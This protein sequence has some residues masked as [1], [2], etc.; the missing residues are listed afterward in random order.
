MIDTLDRVDLNMQTLGVYANVGN[1]QPMEPRV[2]DGM[3]QPPQSAAEAGP[4]RLQAVAEHS[5]AYSRNTPDIPSEIGYDHKV[6]DRAWNFA[7][8]GGVPFIGREMAGD[9]S[10]ASNVQ[11]N[12]R[13]VQFVEQVTGSILSL[14]T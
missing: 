3:V 10:Y 13:N 2:V 12:A 9:A 5:Y 4:F 1:N 8:T 6:A 14:Y 11:A 7:N